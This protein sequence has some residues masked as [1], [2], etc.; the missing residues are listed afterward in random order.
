MHNVLN[1][2]SHLYMLCLFANT[3]MAFATVIIVEPMCAEGYRLDSYGRGI[4]AGFKSIADMR[5][6]LVD[7]GC[8]QLG[9]RKG[10]SL[11]VESQI[12]D[13]AGDFQ[14]GYD[15]GFKVT[16]STVGSACHEA[17]YLAGISTLR[18]GAR[19]R[20]AYWVGMDCV[21]S[22]NYGYNDG[23]A[24]TIKQIEAREPNDTCYKAGYLDG[25]MFR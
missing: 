15:N 4:E 22:Y 21:E 18:V 17:G 24:S 13:C 6:N 20:D 3:S 2:L 14:E 7:E 12:F 11:H 16:G 8:Y 10:V 1:K 25:Q 19:E 5:P 9:V 23:K